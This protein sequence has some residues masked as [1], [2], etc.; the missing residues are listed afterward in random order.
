[1]VVAFSGG[2][3]STVLAAA[4]R[5]A[6]GRGNAVAV[7]ADSP[8]LARADLAEAVRLA[9]ALDLEHV[10][11][12]TGEVELPAYREN[13]VS[14][15]FVCKHTLFE[16]LGGIASARGIPHVVYGVLA[17]DAVADR[18]GDQAARRAGVR[19]PLRDAGIGKAEVRAIARAMGLPNW[20]RPQNACLSSRVPH[21]MD[22]TE[23]KL[24]QIEQAEGLLRAQGFRQVRV[25]HLGTHAR[26]EVGPDE[27]ARFGDARLRWT[28]ERAFAALG[29]ETVGLERGGYREGGADRGPSDEVLLH[30]IGRC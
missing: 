4:A 5:D 17:D 13:T 29:F 26:I 14:R 7:T 1:V 15:C 19:A 10:V 28:V 9:A 18:P 21:G 30:A 27:V 23:S 2:V 11:V 25:R 22:V 6:L 8:S 20:N 16:A 3:D 12:R 24:L